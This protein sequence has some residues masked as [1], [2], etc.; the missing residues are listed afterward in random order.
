MSIPLYIIVG[1]LIIVLIKFFKGEDDIV[2][3]WWEWVLAI[4]FWPLYALLI[5]LDKYNEDNN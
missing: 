1:V 4:T 2:N 3:R 5:I